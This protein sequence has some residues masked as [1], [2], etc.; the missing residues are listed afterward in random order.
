MDIKIDNRIANVEL[1]ERNGETVKI[2]VDKKVYEVDVVM[3]EDMVYSLLM[4][5]DSY[6][7]E[8]IHGSSP[9]HYS[10]NTLYNSYHIEILDQANKLK[11][12]KTKDDHGDADHIVSPMPAKVVKVMVN[13]GETVKKGQVLI[14]VSAMKME[15]EHKSPKDAR[16]K[17]IKVKDEET[18]GVNDVLIELENL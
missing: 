6:N 4:E 17:K 12:G 5:G 18:V 16:V 3:V 9:F 15:I 11:L 13:E 10:V 8:M 14:I 1:L 2:Q 7:I